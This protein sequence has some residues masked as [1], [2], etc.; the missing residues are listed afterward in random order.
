LGHDLRDKITKYLEAHPIDKTEVAAAVLE[1]SRDKSPFPGLRA[2]TPEEDDIFFGRSREIDGLIKRLKKPECRFIVVVGASGSGK[3]SLVAAGLLPTL[4]KN[5]IYGSG[6]WVWERFT[7]GEMSEN[8]FMAL[9]N[10]FKPTLERHGVRPRDMAAEL[11]KD[12]SSI[13]KFLAMA[14]ENKP[15]WAEFLLFI[16]QFE[17]LFTLVDKKYQN[18]FVNFLAQAAKTPRVRTVVTMRADFYHRC[19]ELPVLD[20]LLEEGQYAL[21]TPRIGALYEMITWPAEIAKVQFQDGL[22]Q[23]ILDD[24]GAEPGALPLMAFAL[25]ELWQASKGADRVLTN[26]AYDTFKGVRGAIGKRAEDTFKGTLETLKVKEADL[27][28]SLGRVFRELIEVDEG[29]VAT[30][31]RASLSQVAD[32]AMAEALVNALTDARLLV[33][34]HDEARQPMREVAHEA[35]FTNWDRLSEWIKNHADEL[36][37]CRR[38]IRAAQDW[39]EVGAPRFKH[40][41]D[42]ATIK[43]YQRVRPACSLGEDAEVVGRFLSAARTRQRALAG[44]LGL[45]VIVLSFLGTDIWLRSREM[46]WKVLRIWALAQVRLYDGPEMMPVRAGSFEMGDSDCTRDA[47]RDTCPKHP[48]MIKQFEMGRYEVTFDQYSA[49]VLDS[50]DIKLPPND[51]HWGRGSRPVIYVSWEDAQKYI[52][53]LNDKVRP[54]KPF[55]LPTEAEWEYACRADSTTRFCFGDDEAELGIYAWY[56][57]NSEHTTHPVGQKEPNAWG[58]YDMHGNVWEWVEDDWHYSYQ[59]APK[60]GSAWVDRPRHS[61]RVLRGGSWNSVAW[62]IRAAGR[63]WVGPGDRGGLIGFRLARDSQLPLIPLPH[64]SLEIAACGAGRVACKSTAVAEKSAPDAITL[65]YDLLKWAI[66]TLKKFPRD[67][68][69]LLGDRRIRA[70]GGSSLLSKLGATLLRVYLSSFLHFCRRPWTPNMVWGPPVFDRLQDFVVPSIHRN[71]SR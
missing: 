32:G 29:G 17:E 66:P 43:Q 31:R 51:E 8:P 49:F 62:G 21:L 38:L 18:P 1:V 60:N 26:A 65:T 47:Q 19:L 22:A 2:F 20:A 63:G 12:A 5:A 36:R 7:P 25:S 41:P 56:Q 6:D 11:E 27:E 68:Q 37:V 57:A 13:D 42:R 45:V 28:A 9:A 39:Q 10:A 16:D 44:I 70:T 50:D 64:Y 4:K 34:S 14:L 23:R 24:T 46:N 53:W 35:I 61:F 67:Q 40:L 71:P 59:G 58:L 30:R 69:F 52:K 33:A 15:T 55:R 3:S 54:N 48:V